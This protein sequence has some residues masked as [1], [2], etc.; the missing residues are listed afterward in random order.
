[1]NFDLIDDENSAVNK[2]GICIVNVWYIY[3]YYL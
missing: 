3:I 2:F 1:V